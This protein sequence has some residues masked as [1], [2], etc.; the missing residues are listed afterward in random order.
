V[1]INIFV[2]GYSIKL[3]HFPSKEDNSGKYRVSAPL[4][5]SMTYKVYIMIYSNYDE[6]LK[7]TLK[8]LRISPE[9]WGKILDVVHKMQKEAY[10]N[11]FDKGWEEATLLD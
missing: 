10:K 1:A 6:M 7:A 3:M 2:C 4:I 11:G 8:G 9:D 5:I